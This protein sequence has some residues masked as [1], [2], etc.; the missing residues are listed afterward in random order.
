MHGL[1]VHP[2]WPDVI[3]PLRVGFLDHGITSLSI[4][5]PILANGVDAREYLQLLPEVAGRIDAALDFLDDAGYRNITLV[6]HSMGS[7]M[8]VHYLSQSPSS[9]VT[10]FVAIGMGAGVGATD[11]GDENIVALKVVEVP[12][13]D[14]FGSEDL[15]TVLN[16]ADARAA[17]AKG[18]VAPEY[19]QVR[20]AGANH[21]FQGHETELVQQVLEWLD[22]R[23]SR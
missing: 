11:V 4:Q 22:A 1:G 23:S 8:A 10:S 14:L 13:L 21:F 5:M 19:S 20:V 15:D 16:S 18:G 2:N 17:A 7:S 3:Y 9:A 6:A 12:V